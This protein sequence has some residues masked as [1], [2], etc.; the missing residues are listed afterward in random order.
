M[1]TLTIRTSTEVFVAKRASKGTR[2]TVAKRVG[3]TTGRTPARSK[4]STAAPKKA[5]G[6]KRLVRKATLKTPKA[7]NRTPDKV[8][9][10]A[11]P[12]KA[13]PATEPNQQSVAEAEQTA[14]RK[15]WRDQQ[16]DAEAAAKTQH[17]AIVDQRAHVR[18]TTG[19]RWTARKT[20]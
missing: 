4:K 17:G 15:T 8:V 1:I 14:L 7:T 5:A 19:H 18:A 20:H 13:T 3:R 16:Q 9:R 11:A 12:E 6:K 10:Q 2:A